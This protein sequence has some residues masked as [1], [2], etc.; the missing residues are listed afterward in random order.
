M[1]RPCNAHRVLQDLAGCGQRPESSGGPWSVPGRFVPR[2]RANRSATWLTLSPIAVAQT[3]SCCLAGETRSSGRASPRAGR[4]PGEVPRSRGA[5]A[6]VRARRNARPG[7]PREPQRR[8]YRRSGGSTLTWACRVTAPWRPEKRAAALAI[9]RTIG[10]LHMGM[11]LLGWGLLLTPH[12]E[13]IPTSNQDAPGK[14]LPSVKS[15]W[16]PEATFGTMPIE[17]N[18]KKDVIL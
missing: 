7:S 15:N 6:L 3:E 4:S 16:P 17:A 8:G 13:P 1:T 18:T 14:T 2:I 11:G 9:H 10:I 12:M 5:A